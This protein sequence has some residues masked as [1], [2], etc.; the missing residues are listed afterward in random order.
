MESG[1]IEGDRMIAMRGP[2]DTN[3]LDVKV[4]VEQDPPEF[5]NEDKRV[6]ST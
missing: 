2:S 3:R 1:I 5:L 4:Q 6:D